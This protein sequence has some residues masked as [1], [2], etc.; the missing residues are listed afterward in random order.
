MQKDIYKLKKIEVKS[1]DTKTLKS[2]LKIYF[3]RNE[4]MQ[5]FSHDFEL[6]NPVEI[7]NKILLE[8]K[9]KDKIIVEDSD[10]VLKNIYIQRIENEEE[11]EA[12]MLN[13]FQVLCSKCA[14][15]K[16]MTKAPEYMRIY[17]EIKITKFI[18]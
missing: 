12:K 5:E 7:V 1:F 3:T 10:D 9:K 14:K 17:D 2:T 11:L 8:I 15:L 16:S 18:F 6:R 4:Q 13:F